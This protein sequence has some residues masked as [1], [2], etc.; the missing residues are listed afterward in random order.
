MIISHLV[1]N[2]LNEGHCNGCTAV[3]SPL[4][5]DIIM[6]V[7]IMEPTIL[8]VSESMTLYYVILYPK[9]YNYSNIAN[10]YGMLTCIT[11]K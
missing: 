1:K 5:C 2:F 11:K 8:S 10:N 7:I 6:Y 3:V 4:K 9:I